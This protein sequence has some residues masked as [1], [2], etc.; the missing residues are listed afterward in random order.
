MFV[1][2]VVTVICN[3]QLIR[4]E[5]K[6]RAGNGGVYLRRRKRPIYA[7]LHLDFQRKTLRRVS[8]VAEHRIG[9]AKILVRF[10]YLAPYLA[11]KAWQVRP[12]MVRRSGARRGLA[13]QVRPGSAR[14]AIYGAE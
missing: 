13:W 5:I 14:Q 9:N 7:T 3:C 6:G 8:S 11:G 2:F 12:G 4:V 10:Q 1:W